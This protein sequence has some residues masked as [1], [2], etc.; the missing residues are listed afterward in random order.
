MSAPCP[1]PRKARY[2]SQSLAQSA[3]AR[4]A[5]RSGHP[6]REYACEC[7][8]W[9]LTRRISAKSVYR[10]AWKA[11]V[12]L[13]GTLVDANSELV[14]RAGIDRTQCIL[15]DAWLAFHGYPDERRR[16][17]LVNDD[18]RFSLNSS[19][20]VVVTHGKVIWDAKVAEK[21]A[22]QAALRDAA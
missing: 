2:D 12:T 10:L 15:D 9:H 14:G 16:R 8:A 13:N 3:G 4:V 17:L 11:Q 6:L 21:R 19:G 22:A 18:E 7:S 5:I 20:E 1:T